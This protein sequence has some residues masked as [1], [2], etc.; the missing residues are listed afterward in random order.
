M[1]HK[2]CFGLVL[3]LKRAISAITPEK[4]LFS[5]HGLLFSPL[6]SP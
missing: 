3:M 4:T 5:L 2:H 6:N 1:P